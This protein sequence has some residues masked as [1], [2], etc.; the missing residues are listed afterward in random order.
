MNVLIIYNPASGTAN[1]RLVEQVQQRLQQAG[2]QVELYLTQAANDATQFLLNYQAELDVVVAAG[3]DGTV[4]EV[5]NGL[6]QR[7]SS[8]YALALIPTGTTNVL[9]GELK[10]KKQAQH[11]SDVILQGKIQPIYP[12]RING[13][14]FLLMAGVGY[15][16]WVVDNVNLALKKKVGKLA[17]VLSMLK[18]LPK[19]GKKHYQVVLDGQHYQANSIIITN[20]RLYGGKFKISKQADLSA[21]T[22]QVL[23]LQGRNMWSLLISLIGLPLGIMEKMPGVTSVAATKVSIHLANQ[24]E[25]EPVQADGDSLAELPLELHME[26]QPLRVLIP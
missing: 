5:I 15:D 9:A 8:S 25:P 11:L 24:T 19:F 6:V 13:R 3:G 1:A 14:R 7:D 18:Q 26:P 23:M 20:G 4:N 21:P 2:A 16:A 12:G 22:T 17:Y 10:L